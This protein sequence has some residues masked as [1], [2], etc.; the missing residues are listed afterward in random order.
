MVKEGN[1]VWQ[2]YT[3]LRKIV[4]ILL[5]PK[6]TYTDVLEVEL[7]IHEHHKLYVKI[8][9]DLKY[10]FHVL[11]HYARM[12]LRIGPLCKCWSMRMESKHRE[13]KRIITNIS[14]RI[15]VLQSVGIRHQLNLIKYNY[16]EYQQEEVNYGEVLQDISIHAYFHDGDN[17][18]KSVLSSVTI[19]EITYK[20]GIFLMVAAIIIYN[21]AK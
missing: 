18:S 20:K 3:K 8:F 5:S 9:G 15:N 17:D 10:K 4:D 11:L 14:S 16:L 12:M 21:L 13:I 7:Y 2:L 1:I 6:F 19:N